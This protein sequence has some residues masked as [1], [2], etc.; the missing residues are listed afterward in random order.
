MM[1]YLIPGL[2]VLV[3]LIMGAQ[4]LRIVP[5]YQRG[6]VERLG[7]FSRV[8]EPGLT[9]LVPVFDTMKRVDMREQVVD[10]PPQAVITKDNVAVDVDAV[11]YYEVTDPAHLIYNVANFILAVVKLAQTN[12]RNVVGDMELDQAL[13]S[14]DVI[15]ATMR[16][17]LDEATH[18]WGARVVRMEL[19]RID[20]PADVTKS[21]HQ[22][23]KAERER[24]AAITE[25]E[26]ARASAILT[27]EGEA[28]AVRLRAEAK[29]FQLE[30]EAEGESNAITLVFSSIRKAEPDDRLIAIRYLE[31]LEHIAEGP[32]NKIFIP[33]EASGVLAALGGIKEIFTQDQTARQ[34]GPQTPAAQSADTAA[35]PAAPEPEA[36]SDNG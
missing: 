26:G 35:L 16:D 5:P 7:R 22:Q 6:V 36:S 20:P 3:V 10:V 19:Q 30:T 27:A 11:I 14:R 13:T 8:A 15:N 32:A 2:I 33:Y 4:S 12:L 31:A 24:R 18:N 29:R 1:E 28:Q 9:L 34:T 17:V 21:M 23:M 25:A